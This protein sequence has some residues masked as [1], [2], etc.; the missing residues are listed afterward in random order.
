MD[1]GSL[2]PPERQNT[3]QKKTEHSGLLG[4]C[5]IERSGQQLSSFTELK[6]GI[7]A[8]TLFSLTDSPLKID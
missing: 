5:Q 8:R 7:K 2:V 6:Q 1:L 3:L 4:S